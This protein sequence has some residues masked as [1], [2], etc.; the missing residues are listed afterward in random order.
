LLIPKLY[1]EGLISKPIFSFSLQGEDGDSFLDVGKIQDQA[2]ND[3]ND[4]VY[5]KATK[6]VLYW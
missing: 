3:T 1:K 5:L 2:M 4:L 6:N